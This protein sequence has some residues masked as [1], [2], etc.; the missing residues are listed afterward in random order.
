MSE[1]VSTIFREFI[2]MVS[3]LFG[4]I[5]SF[6]WLFVSKGVL[7]FFWGILGALIL[8]CVFVANVIYPI[9]EK[10]AEGLQSMGND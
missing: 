8:P 10:W 4:E 1:L 3:N 7:I 5:F 2:S 9:W 6:L